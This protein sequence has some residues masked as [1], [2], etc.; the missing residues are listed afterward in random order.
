M[1]VISR[2]VFRA[3]Q[4]ATDYAKESVQYWHGEDSYRLGET[5]NG[6]PIVSIDISWIPGNIPWALIYV[7]EKDEKKLV[8]SI[9]IHAVNRMYYEDL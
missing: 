4:S 7:E 3:D 9:P 1:K 6:L 5:Y 2:V 8:C